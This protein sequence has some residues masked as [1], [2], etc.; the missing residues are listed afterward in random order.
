MRKDQSPS[1][2]EGNE[3]KQSEY[4]TIYSLEGIHLIKGMSKRD[5]GIVGLFL[6]SK[7]ALGCRLQQH[8]Q[9]TEIHHI[10]MN[11]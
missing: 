6:S 2:V 1:L 5:D 10:F 3:K 9:N 11:E 7:F 4:I 8:Q